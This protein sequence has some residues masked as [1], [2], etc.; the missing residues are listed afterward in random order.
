MIFEKLA[1]HNFGLFRGEQVL[2][3]QPPSGN[4]HATPIILF[5]GM[6]FAISL[7]DDNGQPIPKHRLSEGEKQVFAVSVL[8][9]LAQ[10]SPRPLPAI[11]DTPMARLD[12]E[13]RLHL[14]ERY[15]PNASHQVIILSTDTEVDQDFYAKLQP[16]IARAYHLNYDE[17][18]K[19]TLAREGYFW[20]PVNHKRSNE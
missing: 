10:S 18:E 7:F 8:W 16:H 12:S 13:H 3:L 6:S 9:G 2:D 4:G 11:I 17:S 15:F 19:V 1:L 5:G 14:I 20:Q